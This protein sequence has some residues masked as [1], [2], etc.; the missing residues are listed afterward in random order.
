RSP[1]QVVCYELANEKLLQAALASNHPADQWSLIK[2]NSDAYGHT[3]GQ[4][5]SYDMQIAQG[6]WLIAWWGGLLLLLMALLVYRAVASLWLGLML[7]LSVCIRTIQGV[8]AKSKTPQ[9]KL[10]DLQSA[11]C[12]LGFPMASWQWGLAAS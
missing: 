12:L 2:S 11:D 7:L 10:E 5:E 4:H 1:R 8:R 3:L 9:P 6:P